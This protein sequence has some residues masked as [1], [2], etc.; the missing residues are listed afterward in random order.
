MQYLLIQNHGEAP[1]QGYTVLG[2]SGTRGS[3]EEGTIG[4]FGSGTKHAINLCLR[5][6][7]PVWVYCGKTRLEFKLEYE[8]IHEEGLDSEKEVWHVTYRKDNSPTYKRCGWDPGC[9]CRPRIRARCSR[10]AR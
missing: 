1:V 6:N 3:D 7:L 2:Y 5:H 9:S 4:Q 10:R 8:V